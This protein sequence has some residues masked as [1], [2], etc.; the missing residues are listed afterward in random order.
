VKPPPGCVT[1]YWLSIKS[2]CFSYRRRDRCDYSARIYLESEYQTQPLRVRTYWYHPATK[3]W[4]KFAA[5]LQQAA[6]Q[7]QAEI[8]GEVTP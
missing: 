2:V 5:D 3:A 6:A 7:A 8:C 1:K 4:K